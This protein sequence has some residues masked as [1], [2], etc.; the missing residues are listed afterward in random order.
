MKT[1]P[2][3]NRVF[4]QAA[5]VREAVPHRMSHEDIVDK[6][7]SSDRDPPL[8]EEEHRENDD[9]NYNEAYWNNKI[10][11]FGMRVRDRDRL[12]CNRLVAVFT[13]FVSRVL[14]ID[15]PVANKIPM[16]ALLSILG[17]TDKLIQT[18]AQLI[19]AIRT[20]ANSVTNF[21]GGQTVAR[22]WTS[23]MC[24]RTFGTPIFVRFVATFSDT[25]TDP[26]IRYAF[27]FA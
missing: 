5:S 16:N 15:V 20:V 12:V 11:V 25:I 19:R 27:N 10:A 7:R 6:V 24:R 8:L 1:T 26:S 4:A 23:V 18:A 17:S 3:Q 13:L 2:D 22:A 14:A 9:Q 21:G